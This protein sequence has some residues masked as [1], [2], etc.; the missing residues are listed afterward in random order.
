CGLVIDKRD[1]PY[2]EQVSYQN[3]ISRFKSGN[4]PTPRDLLDYVMNEAGSVSYLDSDFDSE[5]KKS[6]F[7]FSVME[8][9]LEDINS[10]YDEIEKSTSNKRGIDKLK[11]VTNWF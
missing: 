7:G 9:E 3:L 4:K 10:I 11:L 1:N 8:H 6:K 5:K 2:S